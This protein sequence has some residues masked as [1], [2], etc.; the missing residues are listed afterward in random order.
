MMKA[1]GGIALS[2]LFTAPDKKPTFYLKDEYGNT[3]QFVEGESWFNLKKGHCGGVCGVVIGVSDMTKALDFYKTLLDSATVVYDHTDSWDGMLGKSN[4]PCT[5]RRV[6]LRKQLIRKGAFSELL[7]HIDI[8]LVECKGRKLNKIFQDRFWG[9]LGFIHL[10]LDVFDMGALKTKLASSGYNFTVDSA[11]SFDM[12]EAAG[13]FTYVEDPDGTL[14]EFVETHR[15]P[16]MKKWNLYL[17][18]K[19]RK[20][21]KPLPRWMVKCL[22][23]NRVTD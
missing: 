6:L 4:E 9:D 8:E 1:D 17:N 23:F 16:I 22:G 21:P 11:D 12:G 2:E 19:S 13:H 3:F 20:E 15:V 14:I 18:V 5:Y 10:C 7:G